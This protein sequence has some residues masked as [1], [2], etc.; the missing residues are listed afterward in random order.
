MKYSVRYAHMNEASPLE[1][2]DSIS[3]G[4]FIGV[5]G[6]TG[7]SKWPHT[8]LDLVKGFVKIII[9]LSEIGPFK[10]YKPCKKQ[11]DYFLDDDLYRCKLEITTP[12]LDK[13]YEKTF[14]KKHHAYDLVPKDRHT[15]KEHFNM[16]WNRNKVKNTEVLIN[17]FDK[18][19]YGYVV[20]IG[21]ETL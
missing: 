4:D 12:Y 19:G 1:I 14:K 16:Y 15:S 21:Y 6:T 20:A 18:N 2:G 10:K 5:M 11:L 8:H 9:R 17:T 13:G 3:Y 7:Q